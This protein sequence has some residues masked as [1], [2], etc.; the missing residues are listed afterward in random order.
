MRI[1]L[2]ESVPLQVL[3]ALPEHEVLTAQRMGWTGLGNGD[4]LDAAARFRAM[5]VLA[6]S[7]WSRTAIALGSFCRSGSSQATKAKDS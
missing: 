5:E 4:L 3:H 7:K 6:R 2:D 1:L